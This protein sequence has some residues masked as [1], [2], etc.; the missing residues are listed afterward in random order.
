MRSQLSYRSKRELLLQIA[1]R[2]REASLALK[3][4]I[5]DEF[6]AATGYA[7]K[8]AIRLLSHPVAPKLKIERPRPARYGLEVQQA[9]HLAWTAANHICAKRLIPFLPTLVDSLERHGHLQL[10]EECRRQL[11]SMSPATADRILQPYRRQERHGISTTRS[12]TLL[13]KQIP[14]RTFNDWNETTPGFME[15]DLVAHCG[16]QAEGSYLFTL[17]LTDIATGWTECLPLLGRGQE[18]VIAALKRARQLL[19]FP[20]LGI[21]TDNG[22]EFINVELAAYCQQEQITFTRGRPRK[23]NDQCYVEQKN[24]QIVRQVVGYDRF[25]GELAYRQ[26]T[27]L[28]RALRVYVNCFQPSMKLQAKER[29]G[30]KVRRSYD[31]AQTPMQ[32]LLASGTIPLKPQQE[33]LRIT[34]AL[35][36]LRLL[37][38]LEHLQKAL[39]QHAVPSEAVPPPSPLRFE[40]G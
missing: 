17:T 5:L 19:P 34:Q 32:R 15:A 21:D 10:S 16:S 7:R 30:S 8:Y 26:L 20:L 27:E 39:W 23:S 31:Q 35:D 4:V 13:K 22:G 29:E 25:T 1:P 36:P 37:S 11:L 38:Q 14:I 3:T 40:V 24:G 2:Y 18:A 6:V 33:L 9:L 28:Y 12:G